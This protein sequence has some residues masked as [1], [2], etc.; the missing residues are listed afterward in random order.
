[1]LLFDLKDADD[2]IIAAAL[3]ELGDRAAS[4]PG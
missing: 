2:E 4:R 3:G 1:V